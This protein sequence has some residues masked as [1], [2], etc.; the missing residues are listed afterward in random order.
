M[1]KIPPTEVKI[2]GKFSSQNKMRVNDE[3]YDTLNIHSIMPP[4]CPEIPN[5][6]NDPTYKV[7]PKKIF[8]DGNLIAAI[9]CNFRDYT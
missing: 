2:L 4:Y 3:H 8:A 5:L 1:N 7:K 9:D 6:K